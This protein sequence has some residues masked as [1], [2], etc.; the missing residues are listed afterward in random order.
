VLLSLISVRE[1]IEVLY[2]RHHSS[3]GKNELIRFGTEG[4]SITPKFDSGRNGPLGVIHKEISVSLANILIDLVNSQIDSAASS[5]F[6]RLSPRNSKT[7]TFPRN[8]SKN[9]E[10]IITMVLYTSSSADGSLSISRCVTSFST[11]LCLFYCPFAPSRCN[12]HH[13]GDVQNEKMSHDL[14]NRLP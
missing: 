3:L 9:W 10:L 2:K 8:S 14:Q 7:L 12:L 11:S 1:E 4:Y 5:P 13:Q 6:T